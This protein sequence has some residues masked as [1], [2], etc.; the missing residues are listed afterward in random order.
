MRVCYRVHEID[1]AEVMTGQEHLDES[2]VAEI[3]ASMAERGWIGAPV[4]TFRGLLLTGNHRCVAAERA[5]IPIVAIDLLDLLRAEGVDRGEVDAT[6]ADYESYGDYSL[7]E[8]LAALIPAR[9][10]ARLG[11]DFGRLN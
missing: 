5:G 7:G 6:I 3:A 11:I 2:L 8:E 4:I 1:G 9:D 10:H